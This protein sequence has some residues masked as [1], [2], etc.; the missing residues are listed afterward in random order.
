MPKFRLRYRLCGDIH[1]R[2]IEAWST[3][4]ARRALGHLHP[5]AV[6]LGIVPL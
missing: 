5:G 1:I 2:D 6:V 3:A 4:C